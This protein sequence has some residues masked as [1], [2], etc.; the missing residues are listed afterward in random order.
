MQRMPREVGAAITLAVIKSAAL[1]PI[2]ANHG[3][4]INNRKFFFLYSVS[5]FKKN[6]KHNFLR[7]KRT[8]ERNKNNS[9]IRNYKNIKAIF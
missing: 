9:I 2:L 6:V 5:S 7:E 4:K 8:C 1:I 3:V